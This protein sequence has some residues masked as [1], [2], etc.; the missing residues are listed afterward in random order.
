MRRAAAHPWRRARPTS[1]R[2]ALFR[3]DHD[4]EACVDEQP[5]GASR[6]VRPSHRSGH[7]YDVVVGG[8][9]EIEVNGSVFDLGPGDAV[10]YAA[11]QSHLIRNASDV[12][13]ARDL[14][15]SP[16]PVRGLPEA[17]LSRRRASSPAS[18][19]LRSPWSWPS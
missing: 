19:R 4:I 1:W 14:G 6:A 13:R 18:P 11:Q 10:Q 2:L 9:L 7:E 15:Q 5:V 12:A 17:G 16:A 8:S 3:P